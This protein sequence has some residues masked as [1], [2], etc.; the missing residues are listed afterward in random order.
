MP[1]SSS[2]CQVYVYDI[3]VKAENRTVEQMREFM[4]DW[5]KKYV[6]QLEVGVGGY[7]HYQCRVSLIKKRR[8]HEIVELTREHLEGACWT[9]TSNKNKLDWL[10]VYKKDTRKAGPWTSDDVEK[11]IP[12]QYQGLVQNLRPWQQE[13]WDSADHRDMRSINFVYDFMGNNGKSTIAALMD[14][15][16]RAIDLPPV[17]DAEKLIES[18]CDILMA[19]NERDPKCVFVDM[20]RAMDKKRLGSLYSAIEQLKKGKVYDMR[21]KYRFWWFDSPQIWVFGNIEPD[22]SL[23]SRDRWRLWQIVDDKL[24]PFEPSS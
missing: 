17:N 1:S 15:H 5:A 12:Y 14:L 18:V 7:E 8:L 13:V 2:D 16:E 9:V 22:L 23:M 4:K 21:Y 11:Y 20:P 19:K 3:T 10:Y 24:E 6:F